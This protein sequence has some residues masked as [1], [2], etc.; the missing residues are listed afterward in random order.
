MF[1]SVVPSHV[2]LDV[3]ENMSICAKPAAQDPP[4]ENPP[5]TTTGLNLSAPSFD[6]PTVPSL[7]VN[8]K[9]PVLLQTAKAKLFNPDRPEQTVE[10]RAVLDTGSQQSYTTKKVQDTLTLRPLRK[11][12]MS[13]L[14]FGSSDQ[15]SRAYDV[16][17]L[18]VQTKD[19]EADGVLLCSTDLPTSNIAAH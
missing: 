6:P 18:G 15:T 3:E 5:T 7:L 11:R 8:G 19:E 4:Q 1:G 13:V 2:V 10:V 14:T 16:V 9:G 12:D 17:E